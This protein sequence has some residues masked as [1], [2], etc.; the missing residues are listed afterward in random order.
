MTRGT[1]YVLMRTG[2]WNDA[3][4][5]GSPSFD[6]STFCDHERGQVRSQGVVSLYTYALSVALHPAQPFCGRSL[7]DD[8]SNRKG[9]GG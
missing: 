4:K 8:K 9:T 6:A 2:R 3:D 5:K 7:L 1:T